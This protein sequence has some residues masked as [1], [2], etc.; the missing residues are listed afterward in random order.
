MMGY[1]GFSKFRTALPTRSETPKPGTHVTP[2]CFPPPTRHACRR[3]ARRRT[4]ARRGD[5]P[6][7][8]HVCALHALL[9]TLRWDGWPPRCRRG[10]VQVCGEEMRAEGARMAGAGLLSFL[11]GRGGLGMSRG[12]ALERR[13]RGVACM[14]TCASIPECLLPWRSSDFPL[15]MALRRRSTTSPRCADRAACGSCCRWVK[16]PGPLELCVAA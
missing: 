11:G 4:C 12:P 15:A 9:A 8:G 6:C 13:H 1:R 16:W 14:C 5:R 3:R 2:H 10:I 7:P